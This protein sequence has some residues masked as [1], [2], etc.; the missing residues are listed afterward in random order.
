[1]GYVFQTTSSHVLQARPSRYGNGHCQSGPTPVTG[2]VHLV[3]AEPASAWQKSCGV[4][5]EPTILE[6]AP[7]Q[8]ANIERV[9]EALR[10]GNYNAVTLA[11]WRDIQY[12]LQPRSGPDC[13]DSQ[14]LRL[15]GDRGCGL[16]TQYHATG[17]GQ[18]AGGCHHH[19]RAKGSVFHPGYPCWLFPKQLTGTHCQPPGTAVPLV[20]G[21]TIC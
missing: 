12:R 5:A 2:S 16:Y 17:N 20:S 7:N 11:W 19:R 14:T 10:Q 15:C 6:A 8:G 21:C 4:R 9:E 3:I 1:M 13:R 18:L